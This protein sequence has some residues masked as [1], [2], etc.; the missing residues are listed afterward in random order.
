MLYNLILAQNSSTPLPKATL[1]C[2]AG[3]A[4]S[5]VNCKAGCLGTP[6]PD[7][8][9]VSQTNACYNSCGSNT[10]CRNKCDVTYIANSNTTNSSATANGNTTTAN[11]NTTASS[12]TVITASTLVLAVIAFY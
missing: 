4:D 9:L 6:H 1:D 11:G 8:A 2:I 10:D 12:A 7:A 5:D 3:C